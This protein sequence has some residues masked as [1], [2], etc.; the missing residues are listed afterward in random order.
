[1]AAVLAYRSPVRSRMPSE[2]SASSQ[3]VVPRGCNPSSAASAWAV[4][5]SVGEGGEQSEFHRAQQG[6]G[7]QKAN[8]S[9][10]IASDAG[11]SNIL[12]KLSVTSRLQ[13]A[14]AAD[15]LHIQKDGIPCRSGRVS[16]RIAA[17]IAIWRHRAFGC[18]ARWTA[19]RRW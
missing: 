2:T 4:R 5:R 10:R 9:R 1:V 16:E 14:A 19:W 18:R 7:P 13:A 15:S 3:S 11:C 6:F 17:H 12:R 8:P